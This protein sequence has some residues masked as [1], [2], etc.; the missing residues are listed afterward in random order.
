MWFSFMQG[1]WLWVS[2]ILI[3][4]GFAVIGRF[5]DFINSALYFITLC[6]IKLWDSSEIN[7]FIKIS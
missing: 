2:K 4:S 5:C 6:E 1:D 7:V 3:N